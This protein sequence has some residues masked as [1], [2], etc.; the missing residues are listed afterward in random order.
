MDNGAPQGAHTAYTPRITLQ[1]S[2]QGHITRMRSK[3]LTAQSISFGSKDVGLL[4]GLHLEKVEGL[5]QAPPSQ[6]VGP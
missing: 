4:N 1:Q 6:N 3:G 5:L 2:S